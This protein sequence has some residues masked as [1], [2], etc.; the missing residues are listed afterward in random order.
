MYARGLRGNVYHARNAPSAACCRSVVGITASVVSR[1]MSDGKSGVRQRAASGMRRMIDCASHGALATLQPQAR[2][3]VGAGAQPSA[4]P[5][6]ARAQGPHAT[7][8]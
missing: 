8:D 6:A 4:A 2:H 1:T 3:F 5:T 7:W